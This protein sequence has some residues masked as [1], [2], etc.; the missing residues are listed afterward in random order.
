MSKTR[1]I[2]TDFWSD[3]FIESLD[4]TEKLLFIYLFTNDKLD[5]CGIYEITI[6]KISFETWINEDRVQKTI[7]KF[8]EKWKIHYIDWYICVMNFTKHLQMN[9]SVSLWV[10]RSRNLIPKP[11]I[12]AINKMGTGCTQDGTLI[13]I[14]WL[15]P[16]PEPIPLEVASTKNPNE[17]FFEKIQTDTDSVIDS[18]NIPEEQREN[19]RRELFKFWN[20]W[21]EKDMRGK[22]R[23]RKEKT[24]EVQ[25]RLTT[26]LLNTKF[27][28]NQKTNGKRFAD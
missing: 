23:W 24:F 11:I 12:E 21:T 17:E 26:W 13:P 27:T 20:Y 10:E 9:P 1:Y 25:R 3:S 7:N 8:S 15:I 22:E 28:S 6:R 14:P 18:M 19:A 5:L 2:K 4:P 16:I